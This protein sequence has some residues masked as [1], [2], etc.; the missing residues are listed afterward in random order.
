[1]ADDIRK[2]YLELCDEIRRHNR[3]YALAKPEITDSQYDELYKELEAIEAD[4]PD[5]VTSDSPTQTVWGDRSDA[6]APVEHAVPMMS[7]S[8]TYNE[9]E[10]R[11]F[12][13]RIEG[14]GDDLF[15]IQPEFTCEPK[16]DGV[17][18]SIHYRDGVMT[19]A[20]TRGDGRTGEN[21][22]ANTRTIRN[23]PH[24]LRDG[25]WLEG[26][27]EIRGEVYMSLPDFHEANR[28]REEEGL[29]VFANPRNT[30][31]GSLKLL[32]QNEV[33]RRPLK[34]WA[35]TLLTHNGP[36]A[37][38]PDLRLH[39]E[40]LLLMDEMGL[41]MV[42]WQMARNA[43][44]VQ[45]YWE[46]L[47]AERDQMDYEVDGVVVKVNDL[48]LRDQLGATA[49]APRWAMAYK[50]KAR[51]EVTR[52]NA[53]KHS[54]GRTGAVTPYAELEPVVVGGVTIR[55]ATLH[56]EDE[57][58]RLKL[59]PGLRVVLERAGDV[60]PKVIGLAPDEDRCAEYT[61][62]TACP[63]C[64][65]ELAQPPGE[66]IRRCVNISCPAQKR[67]RLIHFGSRN[68]MDID[69]LGEKT[70]DLLLENDLV[71]DPGDIYALAD[72]QWGALPGFKEKSVSNM[73]TA[74][75]AS[76]S[77]T[78][79]RLIFGLGIRMVGEG[80][81]RAMAN[82][83]KTLD[84]LKAASSNVEELEAI[85]GVGAKIAESVR[86]FFS[87]ERN[88]TVIEKLRTAGVSFGTLPE[89]SGI[90][91]H[92]LFADKTFVITG[93]FV[94][95]GLTRKEIQ[96]IIESLG[97]KVTGSVSKKTDV[98]IAGESPG[99][100]LDKALALGIPVWN[101]AQT[102]ENFREAGVKV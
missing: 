63:S 1:M 2:R 64:G 70:I 44:E 35:Y 17:G 98:V 13:K 72:E 50:F 47:Q 36:L 66:V 73:R 77:R 29:A 45:Q 5:W 34:F 11:D 86:E 38:N 95:S 51:R 81:A 74:L 23:I 55:N 58:Q 30:T 68:A 75:D 78:L 94:E 65:S 4:H 102:L 15:A 52:L 7:L 48:K 28:R 19:L 20:A 43:D 42:D 14:Q 9:D 53:I 54:V 85:D 39:S 88:L 99:S 31:A 90:N 60:I 91:E 46:R 26:W 79:D 59:A 6:F 27:I 57:I 40:R 67:G 12:I 22:T 62:P 18:L 96:T 3:L 10:V 49:K 71:N 37:Q 21:I 92:P 61:P 25:P 69:G 41:P 93:T 101:E 16:V 87:L 76:K 97:G 80:A 83:Y 33:A 89:S 56:N 84:A 24:E 32:D 82:T 100:K 8:N